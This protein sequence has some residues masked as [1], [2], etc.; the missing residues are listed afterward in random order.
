MQL[1]TA[2]VSDAGGR[3]RNEDAYGQWRREPLLACV[4]ADG[5]GG[6]AG[7]AAASRIAVDAVLAELERVATNGAVLNGATLLRV[8]LRANDAI[9]DAQEH[10]NGL[11]N[12]RSTAVLFG[13]D[14]TAQLAAWAHCGDTRLYCFRDGATCVQTQDHSLVQSMLDANLLPIQD[15]RHHPRR[16]VLFSALGTADDLQIAVSQ[17]PFALADGDAFLLCTDGFWEYVDEAAM[18]GAIGRAASPSAWLA[19]LA[20][21]VRAAA[22]PG[23]DNFTAT[24]VWIGDAQKTILRTR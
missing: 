11:E 14:E 19:L 3:S 18:I 4:V 13:I 16:N 8:L 23:H 6:H 21:H 17:E 22:K 5:A 9:V 7:G 20:A 24:A 12:M 15:V 1:Q 10:G 2:S